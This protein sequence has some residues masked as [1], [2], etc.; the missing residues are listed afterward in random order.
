MRTLEMVRTYEIDLIKIDKYLA[1]VMGCTSHIGSGSKW[2]NGWHKWSACS[3][4]K[5]QQQQQW[6][7]IFIWNSS[8]VEICSMFILCACTMYVRLAVIGWFF[9]VQHWTYKLKWIRKQADTNA[10]TN[11]D[12]RAGGRAVRACCRQWFY[13]WIE[14][15]P[16]QLAR[17]FV[18]L[19]LKYINRCNEI[20]FIVAFNINRWTRAREWARTR[21]ECCSNDVWSVHW[22]FNILAS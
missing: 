10:N 11:I 20:K 16:H 8:V 17:M 4:K 14:W 9:S 19:L 5:Q 12:P 3:A 1:I 2:A 6:E 13:G 21:N 18:L 15:E 7:K 22:M